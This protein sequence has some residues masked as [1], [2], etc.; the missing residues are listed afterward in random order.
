MVLTP[1]VRSTPKHDRTIFVFLGAK[2]I[3]EA[4]GKA[5]QVTNVQGPKVVV[6]GIVEECVVDGKVARRRP[7]AR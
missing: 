4:N 3:V 1:R 6:K 7:T 2:D 5:V